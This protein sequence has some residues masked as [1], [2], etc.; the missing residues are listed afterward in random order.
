M[1]KFLIKNLYCIEAYLSKN[2]SEIIRNNPSFVYKNSANRLFG[3]INF[4]IWF[5]INIEKTIVN[6]NMT[7][8]KFINKYS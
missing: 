4:I 7:I 1:D 8:L 6:E 2:L 3:I 5:K